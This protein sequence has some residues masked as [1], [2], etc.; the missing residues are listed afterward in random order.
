M[1]LASQVEE[2]TMIGIFND[3]DM[4][5]DATHPNIS[6]MGIEGAE[7]Q[8]TTLDRAEIELPNAVIV[9]I[10]GLFGTNKLAGIKTLGP[11]IEASTRAAFDVPTAFSIVHL[12][13]I[14]FFALLQGEN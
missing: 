13:A 14:S 9:K 4:L 12:Y 5:A 7:I 3:C 8:T 10:F 1:L 11:D 2:E 6:T